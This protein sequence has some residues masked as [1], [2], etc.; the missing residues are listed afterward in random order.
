MIDYFFSMLFGVLGLLIFFLPVP[1]ALAF[2]SLAIYSSLDYA[3][4]TSLLTNLLH[5]AI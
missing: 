3:S 2:C 1:T 5:Y 4:F